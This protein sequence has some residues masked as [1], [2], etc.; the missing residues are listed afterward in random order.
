MLTLEVKKREKKQDL[1]EM[2]NSGALPA[3]FYGRDVESTPISVKAAEFKKVFKEAGESTIIVLKGEG[4]DQNALVQDIDYDPVTDEVRH[5]DF[6]IVQKG[7]KVQVNVPLEFV[8]ESP[9]VKAG[10]SLIKVM[11]EIEVE[12]EPSNLPHVIEVDISKI[13]NLDSTI[14][15]ADLPLPSGV[16]ATADPEETVVSVSEA[17]EVEDD[18][19]G[20][21]TEINMEAIGTSEKKGKVEEESAE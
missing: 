1:K 20:G 5:I 10:G 9:A 12:A 21:S 8:G 19:E 6:Y 3:V 7:Q 18:E 15:V 11:H 13:V 14:S 2:R 17:R 4:A 16:V